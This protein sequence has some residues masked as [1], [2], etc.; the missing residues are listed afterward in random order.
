MVF[1]TIAYTLLAVFSGYVTVSIIL[2]NFPGILHKK[3]KT[4]AR[5][6]HISHRGGIRFLIF[7]QNASSFIFCYSERKVRRFKACMVSSRRKKFVRR[8]LFVF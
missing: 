5:A 1:A 4:L 7:Y 2:L 6:A 8:A 3:K